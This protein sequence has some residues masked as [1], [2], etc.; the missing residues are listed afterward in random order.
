MMN[1]TVCPI[2]DH[3]SGAVP[4]FMMVAP[5]IPPIRACEELEGIPKYHV[6]MFQHTAPI[7][8]PNTT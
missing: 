5:T 6:M 1:A 8:A 7:S 4:A 3:I 2:P